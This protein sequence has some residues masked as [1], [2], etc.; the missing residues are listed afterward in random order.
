[1]VEQPPSE[2][3][4]SSPSVPVRLR[5]VREGDYD[6]LISRVD[7]WWGWRDVQL[8]LPRLFFTH[9]PS[10][11]T[12]AADDSGQVAGFLCGLRSEA[13]TDLFYIHFV[14]VDPARRGEHIGAMLYRW[15]FKAGTS[16]GCRRVQA[17]TSPANI[18]SRNFHER[19]GFSER[20]VGNYDGP[21]EDRMVLERRI[22][23][24]F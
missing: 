10:T 21:G 13:E 20:L 9:F 22:G 18:A 11:T 19:L 23:R 12:I 6:Y 14:G 1:M 24:S 16:I 15:A 3:E 4:P 17:V 8:M 2:H 5:P 7:E